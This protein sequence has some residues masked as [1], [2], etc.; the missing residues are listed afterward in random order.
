M[1]DYT[2]KAVRGAG[3]IFFTHLFAS[4][5]GYL[6]RLLLARE[7]TV[8]EYGLVYAI[9]ALFGVVAIVPQ[10]FRQTLSKYVA[11]FKVKKQFDKIK[12]SI[13]IIFIIQILSTFIL[14]MIFIILAQVIATHYLNIDSAYPLIIT[15]A[16]A[17]ILTPIYTIFFGIFRGFQTMKYYSLVDLYKMIFVLAA[18]YMLIK[19]LGLGVYAPMYAYLLVPFFCFAIFFPIFIKK[20]FP[21][22]LKVSADLDKKL[23]KKLWAFGFPVILTGVAGIIFSQTDSLIITLFRPLAD[24]GLYNAGLP[25]AK[26]LWSFSIAFVVV[27]LPISSELWAKK[28]LKRLKYAVT[29]LYKYSLMLVFP[30]SLVM[31]IFPGIILNL[32][33]GGE[34]IAAQDVLRI[35]SVGA[36]IFT[37]AKV[38]N[39]ILVGIGKPK[40]VSRIMLTATLF[41]VI[42]NLI[43]IPAIGINGA[44]ISTLV[45]FLIIFIWSMI[46]LNRFVPVEAD[47][48]N[49]IKIFI[50]GIIFASIIALIKAILIAN[51]WLELAVSIGIASAA[52]FAL[53]LLMKILST[54][55][56]RSIIKRVI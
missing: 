52:Y 31:F 54:S 48:L 3:I 43:L 10:G 19:F 34:Y 25:T 7:L 13:I 40:I 24:V 53:L 51:A 20:V 50:S 12:G 1:V 9:F 30:I 27:L 23:V 47:W 15:Y 26:I 55:E 45:T 2:R 11:E 21:N 44:A 28:D 32:L 17:L 46:K 39:S 16:I 35:L 18:T 37:L 38:N 4:I 22:F 49:L 6:L 56:I 14:G 29:Q 33:F 41:N 36:I 42:G 5:F 8:S